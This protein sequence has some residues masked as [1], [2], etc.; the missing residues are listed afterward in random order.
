[1]STYTNCIPYTYRYTQLS[2][3]ISHHLFKSINCYTHWYTSFIA[4]LYVWASA[5]G[6]ALYSVRNLILFYS[7]LS[8]IQ[9]MPPTVIHAELLVPTL[10][11][12]VST[13]PPPFTI[14]VLHAYVST[15]IDAYCYIKATQLRPALDGP[16]RLAF[17][18]DL[19]LRLTSPDLLGNEHICG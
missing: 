13:L 18:A 16:V 1:M 7:L 12:S 2:C 4:F 5:I 8:A 15:P 11:V 9:S 14:T 19:A 10:T 3:Y 17:W 6:S